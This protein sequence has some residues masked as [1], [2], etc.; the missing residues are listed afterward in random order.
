MKT[1]LLL[2][3]MLILLSAQVFGFDDVLTT[4]VNHEAIEFIRDRGIVKG[5]EDGSFQPAKK[6]NRAEF[7]KIVIASEYDQSVIDNCDTTDLFNDIDENSWP[8]PYICIAKKFGIVKGYSDNTF[9][10]NENIKFVEAAKIISETLN[11]TVNEDVVWY[12]PYIE[13]LSSQEAIPVQVSS[14]DYQVNRGDMA[15][16]MFRMMAKKRGK[17]SLSY[18]DLTKENKVQKETTTK[19]TPIRNKGSY[20]SKIYDADYYREINEKEE[21]NKN[22]R[23]QEQ[24]EE[25]RL[26]KEKKAAEIAYGDRRSFKD[27][28]KSYGK[29]AIE[30]CEQDW[31]ENQDMMQY[32]V[33]KEMASFKRLKVLRPS[34]IE[35]EDD[36]IIF[37][38]CDDDWHNNFS[39]MED[40]MNSAFDDVRKLYEIKDDD[41]KSACQ[42]EWPNNFRMQLYC[43]RN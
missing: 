12:K 22:A 30:H 3:T 35:K 13:N 7:T 34:D 20:T 31:E 19:N 26:A 10:P 9:K 15:E 33:E 17:P 18:S 29:I 24:L 40:C 42:E 37:E 27:Q 21:A 23:I 43:Y 32:C 28:S 1:K 36:K 39:M 6:I 41:K 8:A 5:Y 4:H 14:L 11:L 16:I 25:E 38:G 2:S